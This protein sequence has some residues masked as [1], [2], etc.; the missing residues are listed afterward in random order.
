MVNVLGVF[1][2][3]V[4]RGKLLNAIIISSSGQPKLPLVGILT[5]HDLPAV[6]SSLQLH[7]SSIV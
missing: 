6:L 5:V 1:E 2:D 4:S 3:F 7:G